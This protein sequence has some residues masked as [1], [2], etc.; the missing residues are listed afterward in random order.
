[1][2]RG[3]STVNS[4]RIPLPTGKLEIQKN[5]CGRTTQVDLKSVFVWIC[6]TAPAILAKGAG[7][8]VNVLSVSACHGRR[9]RSEQVRLLRGQGWCA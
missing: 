1:M 7:R 9:G 8:T 6:G 4:T 3:G 5:E 2:R